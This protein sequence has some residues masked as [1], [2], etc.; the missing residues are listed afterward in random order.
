MLI[1]IQFYDVGANSGSKLIAN[2]EMA[3]GAMPKS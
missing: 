1:W 2:S 3:S